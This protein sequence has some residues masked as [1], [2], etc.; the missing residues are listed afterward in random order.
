MHL[1]SLAVTV[2]LHE[3]QLAFLAAVQRRYGLPSLAKTLRVLLQFAATDGDVA[4]IFGPTERG[5]GTS[6]VRAGTV[7]LNPSP[8]PA[9]PATGHQ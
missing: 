7:A 5:E 6:P 2:A 8:V 4:A 9:T 3:E 1:Q